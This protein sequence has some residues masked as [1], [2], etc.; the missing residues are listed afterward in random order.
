MSIDALAAIT[1]LEARSSKLDNGQATIEAPARS[2]GIPSGKA[3]G[4]W[5]AGYSAASTPPLCCTIRS[6]GV[7]PHSPTLC[8]TQD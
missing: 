4:Y 8:C 3:I 6:V 7:L 5:P 2:E 1:H